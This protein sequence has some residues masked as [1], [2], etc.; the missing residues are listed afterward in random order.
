MKNAIVFLAKSPHPETYNFGEEIAL[1][2]DF[3]VFI[4]IDKKWERNQFCTK[5]QNCKII[6]I[7]DEVCISK[8]Y[9]NANI[10]S[11]NTHIKKNPISWDKMFYYFAELNIEYDFLWVFED[12]VFI[13]SISTLKKLHLN[14]SAFDL[15]VPNNFLKKDNILDWHWKH[16]FS[17]AKP[18][19]Y[20]SMVCAC[21]LSRKMINVVKQYVDSNKQLF[22]IEAMLNTLAMQNNLNVKDAFEFKSIVWKGYWGIDEYIL[23]PNNVFHP[24]KDIDMYPSYRKMIESCNKTNFQPSNNLPSFI[25]KDLQFKN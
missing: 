13:P 3:D 17:K 24:L 20:Y 12:D 16:I 8:G 22:F 10:S 1:K 18:P 9:K 15:V 19:Y 6:H 25:T 5:N 2:S 14:Y 21:G 4:I 11:S 23:L 7:T